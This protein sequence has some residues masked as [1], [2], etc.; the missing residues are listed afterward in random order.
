[1]KVTLNLAKLLSEGEI[2]QEEYDRLLKLSARDTGSLAFNILVAFGV[3]AISGGLLALFPTPYTS[4]VLG[5]MTAGFGLVLGH[6]SPTR[7][8]VLAAVSILVGA[9]LLGGGIIKVAEG[10]SGSFLLIAT[11][12]LL[13]GSAARSGLLIS[14]AILAL[15]SSVGARTAYF[16]ASYFLGISEPGLTV[17]LFS[18]IA[19]ATYQFSKFVSHE[20]SRLALIASRTSVILVNLGFWIGSLWGDRDSEGNV[21]IS[22]SVFIV[23]WALALLATGIWGASRNRRWVV[24]TVAAFG[25]IHFYTQW[26]QHLGASPGSVVVAGLLA[27]GGAVGLKALNS[28]LQGET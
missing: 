2:S 28:R 24:N 22:D 26:F 4:I 21:I 25:G 7:W 18:V 13:A 10:S 14:L 12:F 19:I 8:K 11:I 5:M 27:I 23:G 15:A 17:V 16:R 20:L 1:M 6:V 3:I 9:L